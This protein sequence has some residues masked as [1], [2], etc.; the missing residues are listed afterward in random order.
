MKFNN[1]IDII[2]FFANEYSV[3]G[4][5]ILILGKYEPGIKKIFD[6]I[7]CETFFVNNTQSIGID[8]V[9][10]YHNLPFEEHSFD[11]IINFTPFYFF[12][13]LKENGTILML[14]EILNGKD[15]YYLG[16]ETFTVL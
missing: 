9:S 13:F 4:N 1:L 2:Q 7:N 15:Y 10:E 11:I 14:D 8:I 3:V 6:F 5:K 16:D 12:D